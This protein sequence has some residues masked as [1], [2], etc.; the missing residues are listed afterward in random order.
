[1][2]YGFRWVNNNNRVKGHGLS[3]LPPSSFLLPLLFIHPL[4]SR[5]FL[6]PIVLSLILPPS[7]HHFL[8]PS[9]SNYSPAY[10]HC[11]IETNA[12]P[13]EQPIAGQSR[14][15]PLHL[16]APF[17]SLTNTKTHIQNHWFPVA[18]WW[19][20]RQ[21]PAVSSVERGGRREGGAEEGAQTESQVGLGHEAR[22]PCTRSTDLKI[23]MFS[24]EEAPMLSVNMQP[25]TKIPPN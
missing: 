15:S 12:K 23:L 3:S 16:R 7:P 22:E 24:S 5:L 10:R 13:Q 1:M 17:I 11:W 6:L 4:V 8:P 9:S 25:C 18:S 2:V 20:E 21:Q 19:Y 14:T